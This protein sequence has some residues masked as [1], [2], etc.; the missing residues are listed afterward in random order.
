MEKMDKSSQVYNYVAFKIDYLQ[1]ISDTGAGR[2]IMANLRH[3][4]DKMPGEMPEIWGVIFA[5]IPKELKGHREASDAEWAVYTALTLYAFHQQGKDKCMNEKDMSVGRATAHLVKDEDDIER[6]TNRLNL[7]VTS[8]SQKDLSY[9]LRGVVQLL[10]SKDISLDY[11][12]LAKNLYQFCNQELAG[13]IKLSWG[14]DFYSEL[15]KMKEE[16]SQNK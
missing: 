3:G 9:H 13:S 14:R 11:A 12:K 10:K 15:Y 7:V 2:R 16:K 8:V 1:S 6:I 5:T 4:I